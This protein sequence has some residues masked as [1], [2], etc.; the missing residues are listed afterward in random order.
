MTT[1]E[2]TKNIILLQDG[3]PTNDDVDIC[4]GYDDSFS[5]ASSLSFFLIANSGTVRCCMNLEFI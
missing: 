3:R 2:A 5:I 4:V 1:V